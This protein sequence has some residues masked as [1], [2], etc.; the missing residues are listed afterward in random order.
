MAGL[1]CAAIAPQT[2]QT[3]A[4]GI[5]CGPGLF[6]CQLPQMVKAGGCGCC[7]QVLLQCSAASVRSRGSLSMFGVR[8]EECGQALAPGHMGAQSPPAQGLHL[9]SSSSAPTL[10][11]PP[12]LEA[13]SCTSSSLLWT[14]A[15]S[16]AVP[17]CSGV[18]DSVRVLDTFTRG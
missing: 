15:C 4:L 7:V 1:V 18:P 11:P 13:A 2:L 10:Q 3:V 6:P 12:P 17:L 9:P 8:N 16:A 14:R 5:P